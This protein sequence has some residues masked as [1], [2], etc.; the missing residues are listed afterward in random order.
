[1]PVPTSRPVRPEPRHRR[2]PPTFGELSRTKRALPALG[3]ALIILPLAALATPR[4]N[5]APPAGGT[6]AVVQLQQT[7]QLSPGFTGR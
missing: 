6:P 2:R 4:A 5:A 3:L 7:T 1:M